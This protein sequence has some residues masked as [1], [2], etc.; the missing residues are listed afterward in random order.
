MDF[1]IEIR[2]GGSASA[3]NDY[4]SKRPTEA[5]RRAQIST[6]SPPVA[7]SLISNGRVGFP[8]PSGPP[9]TKELGFVTQ[10]FSGTGSM[11]DVSFERLVANRFHH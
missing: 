7:A 3:A 4:T 9:F 8:L 6:L 11:T 5:G 2:M 10:G 1:L